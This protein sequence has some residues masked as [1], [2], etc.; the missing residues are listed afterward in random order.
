[1]WGKFSNAGQMCIGSDH[2]ILVGT[3]E[4][5]ERFLAYAKKA[6]DRYAHGGTMARI[7]N[8]GHFERLKGLAD[9]TKGQI[10]YGGDFS[11]EE[12]RVGITIVKDVERG[13]VLMGDEIFGPLL[14]VLR[15]DTLQ[16]GV[17]LI[18]ETETPL[19]LYAPLRS[20]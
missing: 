16:E 17:D 6:A 5:E 19:A 15:V 8:E 7:V 13:D 20:D 12:L 2:V 18:R 11:R 1:M 4:R 9:G 14:P 10:V 3:P